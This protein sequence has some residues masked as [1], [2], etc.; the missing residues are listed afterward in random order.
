MDKHLVMDA[1]TREMRV[2][3]H[4]LW[5]GSHEVTDYRVV[6][7]RAGGAV[8]RNRLAGDAGVLDDMVGAVVSGN[9]PGLYVRRPYPYG[10]VPVWTEDAPAGPAVV[11]PCPK[12]VNARRKCA[13]CG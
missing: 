1:G 13:L 2:Q 6:D 4:D 11:T 12:A 10:D 3:Y 9:V 8:V 7:G 5:R